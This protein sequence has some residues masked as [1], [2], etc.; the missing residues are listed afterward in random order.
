[1]Q[2][3]FASALVVFF[4]S[5]F[6]LKVCLRPLLLPCAKATAVITH[7]EQEAQARGTDTDHLQHPFE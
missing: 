5:G 6:D 3:A 7:C 1:M 2:S 4:P